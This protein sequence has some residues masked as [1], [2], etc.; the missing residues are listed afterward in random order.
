MAAATGA[1]LGLGVLEA[2]ARAVAMQRASLAEAK[3]AV[4]HEDDDEYNKE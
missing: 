4:A 3:R 1:A 2:K